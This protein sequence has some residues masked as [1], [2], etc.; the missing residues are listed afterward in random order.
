MRGDLAERIEVAMG[1]DSERRFSIKPAT[2]P[3]YIARTQIE[4][5]VPRVW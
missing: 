2:D 3:Q 1:G 4:E 5:N